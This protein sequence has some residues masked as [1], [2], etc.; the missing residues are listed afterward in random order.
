[1]KRRLYTPAND[2]ADPAQHGGTH[3]KRHPEGSTSVGPGFI[4]VIYQTTEVEQ[5]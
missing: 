3:M 4:I 2:S 1:M 5:N